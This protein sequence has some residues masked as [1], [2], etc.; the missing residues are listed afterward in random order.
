LRA[1]L[2]SGDHLHPNQ[3]GYRAMAETI[4]VRMFQ[5]P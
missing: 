4:D 5:M 3:A 2:D 1:E